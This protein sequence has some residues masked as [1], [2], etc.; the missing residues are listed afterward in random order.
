ML[1]INRVI[2]FIW[3]LSLLLFTSG[4]LYGYYL[5]PDAV[6]ISFD[7]NGNP[8]DYIERK[9]AF[10][11]FAA[12]FAFFNILIMSLERFFLLIPNRMKP[13]PNK[14]YWLSTEETNQALNF[15]LSDWFYSF[16]TII[17]L[18]FIIIYYVFTKINRD[19]QSSI[20]QYSWVLPVCS[21][22]I[23][24]WITYLPFRLFISKIFI[25]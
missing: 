8:T 6:C 3:I 18:C 1:S 15:V 12:V 5:V 19:L 10:Y 13:V 16:L 22:L 9:N 24:A 17:N 23:V 25:R 20:L 21:V 14:A 11:G 7:S 4:L 2:K